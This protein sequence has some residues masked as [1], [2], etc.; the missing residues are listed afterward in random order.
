LPAGLALRLAVLVACV[1]ASASGT[2][3]SDRGI[4]APPTL[5]PLLARPDG[6]WFR[7]AKG[8]V[9]LLRGA[10]YSALELPSDPGGIPQPRD[11][12]F[13]WLAS[14]GFNL[15]RVPIAWS[16]LEPLPDVFDPVFLRDRVDPV[17]RLANDH[18]MQVVLAL[19]QVRW[20]D[21]FAG[22]TG[23]PRWT[24][25][26]LAPASEREGVADGSDAQADAERRAARAQCAFFAGA[27]APDGDTQR[28]HYADTWKLVAQYYQQDQRI[29]GF[30]LFNE[31]SPGDCAPAERFV[32]DA[33]APFYAELVR[34]VRNQGAPQA[35][36][37]QPA[38]GPGSSLLDAPQGLGPTAILAPHLYS[39]TFGPPSGGLAAHV[40]DDFY[41]R[42][43]LL[44]RRL[45]GPLLL[46][47]IG[48]DAPPRGPVRGTTP[49]L[50]RASFA[51]LDRLLAGG[52]V[53]A[54]APPGDPAAGEPALGIANEADA[55]VVARPFARRIA[56]IPVAMR[57]DEATHEFTLRFRDDLEVEPP[58]PSEI[59]VPVKR[60]YP[61]GFAVRVGKGTHWTYD[62]HTQ[63]VLVYR[64]PGSEHTVHIV[65]AARSSAR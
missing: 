3:C 37:Y 35:I 34:V 44:A 30:D 57:F 11:A 8:R 24:C 5:E 43:V 27:L 49:E 52:A 18:G 4:L 50:L 22:G 39:Q 23:A 32:E 38:V 65:P 16:A 51:E 53:W 12:D 62:E 63:R 58:D 61:S 2:A 6:A 55:A 56:G 10:N 25:A 26:G 21:C 7:D 54:Y 14:L 13:A 15:L 40:L 36:V 47:E 64:G 1:V 41:G 20:S 19:Y 59:F 9:V 33:L 48:G 28:A 60:R 31:P 45:G 17:L 46:G 29:V 42:A